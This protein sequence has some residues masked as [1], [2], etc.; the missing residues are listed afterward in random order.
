MNNIKLNS[1]QN[2]FEKLDS[3]GNNCVNISYI[4]KIFNPKGD[5]RVLKGEK[6][7]EEILCEFLD[8]FD[9]NH[10]LLINNEKNEN[11][12]FNL[13]FEEFA[14]FYEY[15]SFLYDNDNDFIN[16]IKKSWNI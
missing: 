7:E 11:N 2:V 16:L 5:I 13:D 14:N 10:Y 15:V 3:N 4:K 6:N 12:K 9:L 8:C 1:V